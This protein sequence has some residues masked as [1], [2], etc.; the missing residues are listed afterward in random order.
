MRDRVHVQGVGARRCVIRGITTSTLPHVT[1]PGLFWP[2]NVDGTGGSMSFDAEVLVSWEF[3]HPSA[4][5]VA[6]GAYASSSAPWFPEDGCLADTAEVFDGFTL[7]GGDVQMLVWDPPPTPQSWPQPTGRSGRISNCV[8]DLRNNFP[9]PNPDEPT[10]PPPIAP[11]Y[12]TLLPGPYFGLMLLK[13]FVQISPGQ[14]GGYRDQHFLIAHNTFIFAQWGAYAAGDP[15]QGGGFRWKARRPGVAIMDVTD[16]GCS[17]AL[18]DPDSSLRG[19]GRAGLLGNLFR[20]MGDP[21]HHPML[22]IE[23]PDTVFL[24]GGPG[25]TPRQTNAFDSA[26]AAPAVVANLYSSPFSASSAYTDSCGTLWNSHAVV[27]TS[28]PCTSQNPP[29]FTDTPVNPAVEIWNG[30]AGASGVGLDPG[31]VGEYLET[32]FA[33]C[34]NYVDWR[35]LPGSPCEDAAY[36]LSAGSSIPRYVYTQAGEQFDT[37]PVPELAIFSKWDGEHWGNPRWTDSQYATAPGNGTDIGFDETHLM[38]MAGSYAND[39]NSHNKNGNSPPDIAFLSPHVP[40]AQL[41]LPVPR[42]MIFPIA[43][44]G[45]TP[46]GPVVHQLA[47][48]QITVYSK[49]EAPEYPPPKV[50]GWINPPQ[51]LASPGFNGQ[52]PF[53]YRHKYI[54]FDGTGDPGLPPPW[55][56]VLDSSTHGVSYG[57]LH[58]RP[59]QLP[60]AFFDVVLVDDECNVPQPA[61]TNCYHFYFNT[62]AIAEEGGLE[63]Q[64]LLRGNMQAEFR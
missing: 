50:H 17:T 25:G 20:T 13:R 60:L 19:V 64:V 15:T 55:A 37:A 8:F 40:D 1:H 44:G 38:I 26:L 61:P 51:S 56:F 30:V 34:F 22:G 32:W 49:N 47:G 27:P 62:Q 11:Q 6:G 18:H 24:I 41:Q 53:G 33:A 59:N 5:G 31:F 2:N 3:A 9:V 12:P 10:N 42:H 35:L 45:S 7:Q 36:P 57:P 63:G 14:P 52:L 29:T 16:P 43:A 28:G 48:M 39:S 54:L 21:L 23:R 58:G 4:L 46:S